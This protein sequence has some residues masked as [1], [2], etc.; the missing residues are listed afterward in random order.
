MAELEVW[1]ESFAQAAAKD[2]LELEPQTFTWASEP[3]HLAVSYLADRSRDPRIMQ[4]AEVGSPALQQMFRRMKGLDPVL[5][6]CRLTVPYPA[7]LV[8]MGTATIVELDG[9]LH[10][11][12]ARLTTLDLY[13]GEVPLGFD[14]KQ[15]KE[16]CR[17]YAPKT[18]RW[19]YGLASK[20]FGFHGMQS[21]RAYHDAVRDLAAWVMG[22]PPLVRITATDEDGEAAYARAKEDN[23]FIKKLLATI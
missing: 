1:E 23:K 5:A 17:E 12:T 15:Y 11:S 19:R 4:R 20:T 9:P 16:M 18:D 7:V 3:G 21:E 6:S 10:F 8:H 22:F 13:P 2:G 14:I